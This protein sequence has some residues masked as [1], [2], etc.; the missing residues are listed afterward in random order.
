MLESYVFQ[1][2][3]DDSLEAKLKQWFVEGGF[4]K[5]EFDQETFFEFITVS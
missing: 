3:W 4:E 2:Q 1:G 5:Y